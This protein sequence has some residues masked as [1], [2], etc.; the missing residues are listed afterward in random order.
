M[1]EIY[2]I[3]K[4]KFFKIVTSQNGSRILQSYIPKSSKDIIKKILNELLEHLNEIL[5]NIYGNYFCPKFFSVL[6][7]ED[8]LKFL[9]KV[10]KYFLNFLNSF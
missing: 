6:D 7:S 4:G 10:Q 3:L 5:I 1:P 2:E 9:E 8:R